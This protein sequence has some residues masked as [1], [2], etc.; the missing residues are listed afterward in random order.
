MHRQIPIIHRHKGIAHSPGLKRHIDCGNSNR[1]SIVV[2]MQAVGNSYVMFHYGGG[3]EEREG[4]GGEGR[5]GGT[6][7]LDDGVGDGDCDG[8]GEEVL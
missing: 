8:G 3:I 4:C 5:A 2:G 1:D 7:I 6:Y